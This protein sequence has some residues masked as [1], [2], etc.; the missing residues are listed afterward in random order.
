VGRPDVITFDCYGTLVDWRSGIVDAFRMMAQRLGVSPSPAA[1]I[2]ALHAEIEPAVQQGTYTSYARVLEL[3][4]LEMA[5]RLG[6]R[7]A[8]GDEAFLPESLPRWPAFP[9]TN[10][11]LERIIGIGCRLGILSNIDDALL[12]ATRKQFTVDFDV[13]VTAQQVRSYKPAHSHFHTARSAVGSRG[14][15]HAAQSYFHDVCPAVALGIPVVW[16]NRLGE[17]PTAR[18]RP[19]AEVRDLAGLAAWVEGLGE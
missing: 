10:P 6:W 19:D 2:L 18:A 14:W 3:V 9:E 13:V 4:A 1:E 11:A 17:V 16:V 8:E 5:A 15:V 7:L 12:D